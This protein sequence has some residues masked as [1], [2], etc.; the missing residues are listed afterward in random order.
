MR[1]AALLCFLIC[2]CRT[3]AAQ[4]PVANFTAS[5][6]AG[7]SPLV[8][9]FA[10]A[11]TGNPTAWAWD[12]G[13][14]ATST[15]KNPSTTYFTPGSYTVTLTVTNAAG[16]HTLTR[17][18]YVTVYGK[19]AVAFVASDS[20]GC[21]PFPV[22]FTDL[23]V[24][25]P[26]T[27]NNGWIWDFGDG[28]QSTQQHPPNVYGNGGNYTVS[29][30]VT[31]DKGCWATATKPAYVAI[32]GGV[33]SDFTFN[34]PVVC[35]T[36]VSVAFANISTGP[37]TLT[38]QWN[39]GDGG[40]SALPAPVHTYTTAGTYPVT[41][42]TTSSE[43]CKDTMLKTDLV[44]VQN[45][46]TSFTA[47]DSA[48]V[49]DAVALNNTSSNG[50]TA[51]LWTFGDGTTSTAPSGVKTYN[52]PGTY[53]IRLLQSY[54]PCTDSA[55]KVVVVKPRPAAAFSAPRTAFCQT[56]ASVSF[57]NASTGAA[58]YQWTFGDGATSTQAS[59]THTYT[60]YGTY[61][62]TLVVM[63]ATGCTDTLRMPGYISVIKPIISFTSLP[64]KGC[65]PYTAGFAA[66][67]ASPEPVASYLWDFG[68]G[69][70]STAATPSYTYTAQ[71]TYTVSL[72]VTTVGGCTQTYTLPNAVTVG[73]KPVV[74][75][76][77]QP[78]VVCAFQPVQFTSTSTPATQWQW[79]F[80]DGATS[81]D[82]NPKHEYNDTG[83]FNVQ[84]VVTN[85]GCKDSLTIDSVVRI[86]PPIAAY[87]YANTCANRLRYAFTDGSIGATSWAWDFGDGTTST[88]RNPVHDFPG[89]GTYTVKLTV[90]N[91]TCNHTKQTVIL[92]ANPT[93]DFTA[94]PRTACKGSTVQFAADTAGRANVVSWQWRFGYNGAVGVGRHPSHRY[95]SSGVYTV[96]LIITD[97]KGCVDSMVKPA[98]VRITGPT[99][100]FQSSNNN[101]CRGLTATFTDASQSD[102]VSAMARWQWNLGD[103]TLIDTTASATFQHAYTQAGSFAVSLK[104]TDGG[105]CSDSVGLPAAVNVS[106]IRAD[107]YSADTVSCPGAA[108]RFINTSVA[109]ATFTS[110]W[111]FGNGAAS[112]EASP[113]AAY[114]DTGL[115]TVKLRIADAFGCTDSLT[116]P[117]YVSIKKP[118]AS[119]TV[120]DSASS[121]TPFQVRFTNTS[122]YYN[123]FVWDLG[124]G[125]S[126]LANPST[127][128]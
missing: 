39:F 106:N 122:T 23:S 117:A 125:T 41:L 119:Y 47:P 36:P 54:G 123:S 101:G 71:G 6:V 43:G 86:K 18:A 87:N 50:A 63:A 96:T 60:A 93:P 4:T 78:P 57:A 24:A 42:V 95:D 83:Y 105:G 37:G 70:T 22:T 127:L 92:I 104:V 20:T 68:N 89:Y 62:V 72:T 17:Q 19:P 38:Y 1:A 74:A 49:G 9:N 12:F 10:D 73:T 16:S 56:P 94:L 99:A 77:A 26:G 40:T 109:N 102:G 66:A 111:R 32:N 27:V 115:Y 5:P 69:V 124:G 2:L 79:T 25:S 85:N 35:R 15:L 45:F 52:A 116:R 58:S 31:N 82:E 29:V 28:G 126:T 97:D 98:Y 64:L 114:S 108:V 65:V 118:A 120:S 112:T 30:K 59:P 44:T 81:G 48:C 67:V 34:Q 110:H 13:N 80:G 88:Q 107:F 51:T 33:T 11:S 100:A 8:V 75:F 53:T 46:T 14:G 128:R 84:L 55:S 113:T 91:D 90:S 3:V 21:F 121:C 76:S 103:G 7:C 61:D